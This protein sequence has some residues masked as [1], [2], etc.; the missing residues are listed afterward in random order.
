VS[1]RYIELNV[2]NRQLFNKIVMAAFGQRRKTLRNSLAGMLSESAIRAAG[3]DPGARVEAVRI[4][5][6]VELSRQTSYKHTQN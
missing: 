2:E 5:Q 1:P 3:V 4:E 6:F